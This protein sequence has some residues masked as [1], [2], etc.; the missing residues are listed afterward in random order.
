MREY[1]RHIQQMVE[2]ACELEDREER[3]KAARSIVSMMAQLNPSVKEV[4]DYHQ[5]LWTHLFLI[6][7]FK[8]DV[9]CP[10]DVPKEDLR[11]QKPEPVPYPSRSIRFKHYGKSVELMIDSL[12]DKEDGDDKAYMAGVLANLMKRSYLSWNRDSVNDQVI[13]DHL[14]RMSEGK[15]KPTEGFT[16]DA[17]NDILSRNKKKKTKSK[18]KNSRKK[19]H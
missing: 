3:N 18:S 8:L 15:L 17:T 19:R 11:K 2:Q 4:E 14:D 10:Y 12:A 5:K 6:S 13:F 16:L 9:D 1:G 7:E